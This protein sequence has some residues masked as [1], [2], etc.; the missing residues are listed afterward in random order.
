MH[1]EFKYEDEYVKKIFHFY[2]ELSTLFLGHHQAIMTIF[3]K[4]E[5]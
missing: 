3:T 5:E 1:V 4:K 2:C